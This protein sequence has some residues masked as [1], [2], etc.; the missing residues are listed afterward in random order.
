MMIQGAV[1]VILWAIMFVGVLCLIFGFIANPEGLAKM[2]DT[3]RDNRTTEGTL[4]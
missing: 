3:I 4:R 1:E 2:R